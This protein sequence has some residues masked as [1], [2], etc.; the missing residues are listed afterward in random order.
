MALLLPRQN[1]SRSPSQLVRRHEESN[2]TNHFKKPTLI[3]FLRQSIN[4]LKD[5]RLGWDFL[6]FSQV[7]VTK[8][9]ELTYMKDAS[10]V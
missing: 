4:A 7:F 3:Q 5:T 9:T 2:T 6:T 10:T 1:L 8:I